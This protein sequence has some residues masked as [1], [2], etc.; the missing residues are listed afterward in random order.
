MLI[1]SKI[2][3]KPADFYRLVLDKTLD[4]RQMI[5]LTNSMI[6]IGCTSK[7]A[8]V[9]E[10]AV[11]N[12]LIPIYTTSSARLKLLE[13]LKLVANTPGCELLYCGLLLLLN[14][15]FITLIFANA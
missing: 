6:R 3:S 1:Q 9:K 2:C 7:S 15:F 12:L 4:I 13:Y 10:H 5:I 14:P 11:S 8:F